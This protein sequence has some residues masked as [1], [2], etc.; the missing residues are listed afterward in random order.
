MG[1]IATTFFLFYLRRENAARERGERDE[2]I[3]EMGVESKKGNG[4][5]ASVDEARRAK[6]DEW[7]GY[8]YTL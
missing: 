2:V 3:N 4:V 6:G 8:R 5:F 7:S 1:L